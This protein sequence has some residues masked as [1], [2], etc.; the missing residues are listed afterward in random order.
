MIEYNHR[1]S[2]TIQV[3]LVKAVNVLLILVGFTMF[4]FGAMMTLGVMVQLNDP[5][6]ARQLTTT[7]MMFLLV[8]LGP[9]SVGAFLA[10]SALRR[11]KRNA[12]EV[13]E[14]RLL[15]L[16]RN[17]NGK[18]TVAVATMEL[19]MTSQEVKALL[20]RC[21]SDG[22]ATIHANERGEVEYLFFESGRGSL[23]P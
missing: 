6:H 8:G 10:I 12:G 17:H 3:I 18:L 11:M 13:M 21:H 7:V 2:Y 22:L 14:R 20:E 15:H 23:M 19:E 4:G 16:A 9:M 1:Q 5:E